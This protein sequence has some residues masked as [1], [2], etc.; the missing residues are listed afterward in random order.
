MLN[1]DLISIVKVFLFHNTKYSK[2]SKFEKDIINYN[3]VM[4]NLP[5]P[6]KIITFGPFSYIRKKINKKFYYIKKEYIC[7]KNNKIIILTL[8]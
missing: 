7:F 8:F 6:I 1:N 5:K 4:Q 3:S 2:H